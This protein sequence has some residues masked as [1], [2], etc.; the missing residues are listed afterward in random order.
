MRATV[1]APIV[2]LLAACSAGPAAWQAETVPVV[3]MT[4][5]PAQTPTPSRCPSIDAGITA[6][7]SRVTPLEPMHKGGIDALTA[8]LMRSEAEKNTRLRQAVAA[9]ERC[10]TSVVSPPAKLIRELTPS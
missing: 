10:R 9:Y 7:A 2:A 4:P 1:L 5:A 3:V 8:A 6:E